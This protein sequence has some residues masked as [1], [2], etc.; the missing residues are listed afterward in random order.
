MFISRVN[1]IV[2]REEDVKEFEI[3]NDVKNKLLELNDGIF[4]RKE[5]NIEFNNY[6]DLMRI[7]FGVDKYDVR[8][9]NYFK[10]LVI[11]V[12][13]SDNRIKSG[14]K[15][16]KNNIDEIEEKLFKKGKKIFK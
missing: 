3:I 14:I 8:S 2:K 4:W 15:K 9:R 7:K 12:L 11:N 10:E 13:F 6:Y 5:N 16:G 1:G